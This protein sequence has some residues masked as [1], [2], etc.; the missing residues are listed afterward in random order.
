M[1]TG[2]EIRRPP[3]GRTDGR[4]RGDSHGRRHAA[5]RLT[6][7]RSPTLSKLRKMHA[8]IAADTLVAVAAMVRGATLRAT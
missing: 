3:A 5:L 4:L 1:A 2:G 8:V 6:N 7:V